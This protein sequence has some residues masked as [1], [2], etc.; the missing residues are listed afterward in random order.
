MHRDELVR[1]GV[2]HDLKFRPDRLALP[3]AWLQ[4]AAI[5]AHTHAHWKPR[6]HSRS[7][8]DDVVVVYAVFALSAAFALS[9]AVVA[10]V[11]A[12]LRA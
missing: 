3:F 2:E 6:L 7:V 9:F 1:V 12:A 5:A 10:M 11:R 4:A 8:N